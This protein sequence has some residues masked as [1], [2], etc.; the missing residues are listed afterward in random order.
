[1][2]ITLT[3]NT[4]TSVTIG[5]VADD[6][7]LKSI[8]TAVLRKLN[9]PDLKVPGFRAG[10]I[11]LEMVE[12]HVNPELLQTEFIDTLLNHAYAQ[13][14]TKEQLRTVGQPEV[15]LKKFVPFSTAEFDIK[16]DVIGEVTLPDYAKIKLA[17]Q[18]AVVEQS[19]VKDVIVSLQRRLATKTDVSRAAKD[20]DE[21]WI[22]FKGVDE[23][24]APVGG[25]DGTDYPLLLGSN[26]FIPGFE[27]ELLGI[28]PTESKSFTIPFPKDYGVRSLQGKRVTF[29]VTCKKVQEVVLPKPDDEFASKA[30]PFKTLAEL[31]SDIKKQLTIEKQRELDANYQNELIREIAAKSSVAIPDTVIDQQVID[32]EN[33]EKQNLINRGQTWQEHLAEEKLTEEEHRKK[34][35]PDAEMQVKTGVVL[36]AIGDKEQVVVTPEEIEIRIQLLKGQYN[37][38]GMQAELDKPEARQDIASRLR[39]EKIID[40]LEKKI[41]A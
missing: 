41:K 13:A 24:G 30:G 33:Q 37:D 40:V 31:K 19:E 15:N 34:N 3:K 27:P 18:K 35:R 10:K 32:A 9:T 26:T 11:P 29:T 5:V 17:K 20:G 23:K 21:V 22:D 16:T 1:M 25:A 2:H 38:P 12:K 28:Q 36:G 4:P 39:I 7:T 8:K 14:I 6:D